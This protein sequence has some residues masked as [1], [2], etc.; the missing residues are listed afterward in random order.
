MNVNAAI[1]DQRLTKLVEDLKVRLS[2]ELGVNE[3]THQKSLSFVYLCVKTM[4]DLEDEEA[5]DALTDGGNDFG[6]DAMHIGEELDGEFVV[7]LF[8]AKYV[9]KNLDGVA[10]FPENG[11]EAAVGAVRYLFDPSAKVQ[12]NPRLLPK[13]EEV[14]SLISDGFIP[15]V[16]VL[17]CNNGLKWTDVAQGQ[18]DRLAAGEQVSW[19]HVNHGRLLA[20]MQSAKPVNDSL[21]LHGKAIVE[22]FDFSRVLIGK[23]SVGEIAALIERHGD[24][25]LER[26]I[27]RYLGLAGNRVNEGIRETLMKIDERPNFYFYNNGITL[28]CTKFDY[29]AL[30]QSDFQVKI[31]DLQV[32]NGGQTSN[33]IA[34][35]LKD[36]G[37]SDPKNLDRA[38]VMIRLYQLSSDR[39]SFVQNITYATNSQNPVDLR[40]LKANDDVQRRLEKDVEQLG[41]VYR[42]KRTDAVSSRPEEISSGTAAEAILS[43]WRRKPHQ[44]KFLAREHF[45][46]LYREIFN[47]Q[48]TGAQLVTAALLFRI[49]ENKR[50]RPEADAPVFLPYAS[51]FLAMQMG[52]HLARDL[53]IQDQAL[54]HRRFEDARALITERGEAYYLVA[55]GEIDLAI[56]EMYGSQG[57]TLQRLAATFRRGDLILWLEKGLSPPPGP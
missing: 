7:T 27:R 28:T 56:K 20:I 8:Q 30:Q 47:D 51:C 54:D 22:D 33:T 37:A 57:Q 35:V 19:E 2:E 25:L 11:V 45:G 32:I 55:L 13:V 41:Y 3:S 9:H 23:V 49:A 53:G 44:A 40:D 16:R 26:N 50:K 36:I 46:K 5:F 52:K 38:F 21:R 6:V 34:K 17:L 10:N 43:V 15:R 4:L 42:R 48:L 18:I 24:R 31:E 1:I 12:A 29:N 14:R 39:E